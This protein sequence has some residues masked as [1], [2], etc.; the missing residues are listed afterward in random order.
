MDRNSDAEQICWPA[1]LEVRRLLS[2]LLC[3]PDKQNLL[4]EA[5]V[6]RLLIAF[7]ELA[8]SLESMDGFSEALEKEEQATLLVEYT[9]LFIGPDRLPAPPYGSVYLEPGRRVLGDTT[10]EVRKLYADEG[11]VVADSVNEPPDHVALE[12][13]FAAFLLEKSA[14]A[15]THDPAEAD[16]LLEKAR[17]FESEFLRSWLPDLA[18]SIEASAETAFYK[19]VARSLLAYCEIEMPILRASLGGEAGSQS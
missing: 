2:G 6:S 3:Q 4:S 12:F 10:E 8:P 9:R 7:E 1:H 5:V 13:E 11:L 14:A 16:R 15:W 17:Q 18:S 19:G